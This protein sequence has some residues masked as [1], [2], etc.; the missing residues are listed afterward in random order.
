MQSGQQSLFESLF[1]TCVRFSLLC[2]SS[3]L[4]GSWISF[5]WNWFLIVMLLFFVK[6]IIESSVQERL[7]TND[8]VRVEE[9]IAEH[10][11][12]I[13]VTTRLQE[14]KQLEKQQQ[15]QQKQAQ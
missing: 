14:K 7:A 5:V 12:R 1:L 2:F 15:Q 13:G 10:G 6:S 4:Q 9:F 3:L 8:A 11:E